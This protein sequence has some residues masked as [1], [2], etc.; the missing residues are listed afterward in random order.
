MPIHVYK[1]QGCGAKLEIKEGFII[2]TDL[3]CPSC[4][5]GNMVCI[6]QRYTFNID[7]NKGR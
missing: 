4:G 5:N 3:V 6:P 1:C 2:R 7:P